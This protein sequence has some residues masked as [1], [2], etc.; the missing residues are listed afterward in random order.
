MDQAKKVATPL[1]H[2]WNVEDTNSPLLEDPIQYRRPVGRLFYLNFTRPDL[3]FS[4]HHL[5]QFMQ[6]PTHCH[7]SATL[8]VVK[9]LKGT[10][11]HVLFY[12]ANTNM[13]I[14]TFCDAD[15]A[16]C[17]LT[18]R[19]VIG[20]C[21]M[22]GGALISWKSK[23]QNIVSRSSAKVEYRSATMTVCELQWISCILADLQ[24]PII[25]QITLQFYIPTKDQLAD[26][27]TKVIPSPQHCSLLFKGFSSIVPS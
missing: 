16:K 24:Q 4:V 21:I 2:D 12:P 25:K 7:W 3:T 1:V 26:V 20:Y 27:F 8:H 10:T 11:T 19:S 14:T 17:T 23:K 22:M 18:R 9:Y 15:W 6:H 13:E 5:S